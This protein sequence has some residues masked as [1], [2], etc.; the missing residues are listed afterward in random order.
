M[1]KQNCKTFR[2]LPSVCDLAAG[3]PSLLNKEYDLSRRPLEC[4]FKKVF[5]ARNRFEDAGSLWGK[6]TVETTV[7][8]Q[9]EK[10]NRNAEVLCIGP[11]GEKRLPFANLVNRF[12]WTADHVGLG[13]VF[14]A[15]NLKAIAIHGEKPVPF[16]AP[17]RFLK[18][19]L[20]L[21]DRIQM[22]RRA[23]RLKESGTFFLLGENGGGL[24]IRNFS[25][26]SQPEMEGN[27]RGF[28]G[29]KYLYGRERMDGLCSMLFYVTP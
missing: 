27:W 26:V 8:I 7:S 14:G 9:E 21:R 5:N 20:S 17:D 13:G 15:K 11:A 10:E 28:Y 22:D 4:Y 19:C 3:T 18:L 16:E 23:S 2:A 25:D 12:S 1:K 24:G 29:R 6:D